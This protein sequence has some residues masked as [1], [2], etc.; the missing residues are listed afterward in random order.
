MSSHKWCQWPWTSSAHCVSADHRYAYFADNEMCIC[1]TLV[2]LRA[3]HSLLGY[4]GCAWKLQ[5]RRSVLL[6]SCYWARNSADL[7]D[8]TALSVSRT[9]F[10]AMPR[11]YAIRPSIWQPSFRRPMLTYVVAAV[12]TRRKFIGRP[13]L[14]WQ[15]GKLAHQVAHE[16]H[17][18]RN[19]KSRRAGARSRL[20]ATAS[21]GSL[22]PTR[23]RC[24]FT[25]RRRIIQR[26]HMSVIQQ[27]V[28]RHP[29]VITASFASKTVSSRRY[30]ETTFA[31][32]KIVS[33][34]CFCM[35]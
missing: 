13:R 26:D 6:L 30:F 33:L 27:Q 28:P 5:Q 7:F 32:P 9:V 20:W 15:R 1:T 19:F 34:V 11:R 35:S 24:K 17:R 4:S 8:I 22:V 16:C 25:Q 10:T 3:G 12:T 14:L 29:R 31:Q 18:R 2:E 23:P 21:G